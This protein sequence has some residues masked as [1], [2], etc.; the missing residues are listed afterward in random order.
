[1]GIKTARHP[2]QHLVFSMFHFCPFYGCLNFLLLYNKYSQ[3]YRLKT[4]QIHYFTV[5]V[6]WM[7]YGFLR[8]VLEGRM[9]MISATSSPG[10]FPGPE[11]VPRVI[12]VADWIHFYHCWLT[13]G[14]RVFLM[15]DRCCSKIL[16]AVYV[17]GFCLALL[18]AW[19]YHKC[20]KLHEGHRN[21]FLW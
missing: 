6:S 11:S 1:M 21:L 7:E 5:D 18:A 8:R 4:M 16:E 3:T 19:S 20:C 10:I 14:P 2:W 12:W 15:V 17:L 13:D 9:K